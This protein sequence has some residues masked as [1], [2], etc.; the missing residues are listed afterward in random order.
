MDE[1]FGAVLLIVFKLT[2]GHRLFL[3][4]TYGHRLLPGIWPHGYRLFSDIWTYGH[5][6]FPDIWTYGQ[7]FFPDIWTYGHRQFFQISGPMDTGF[8]PDI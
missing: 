8:F 3:I 2:N 7:Q 1:K 5:M 6:H 4:L